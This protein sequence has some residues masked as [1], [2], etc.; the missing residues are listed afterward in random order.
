MRMDMGAATVAAV[1]AAL[2]EYGAMSRGGRLADRVPVG[3]TLAVLAR[4]LLAGFERTES[5]AYVTLETRYADALAASGLPRPT[6]LPPVLMTARAGL[7][8]WNHR[9]LPRGAVEVLPQWDPNGVVAAI[10]R[11]TAFNSACGP[12]TGGTVRYG[13]LVILSAATLD[14]APVEELCRA[15]AGDEAR[16]LPVAPV[17]WADG[18]RAGGFIVEIATADAPTPCQ[19]DGGGHD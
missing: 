4:E 9:D 7:M 10:A 1:T 11:L 17:E 12:D 5:R 16:V 8:V 15:L 14:A 13:L 3:L 19:Q 2:S 6:S 18:R